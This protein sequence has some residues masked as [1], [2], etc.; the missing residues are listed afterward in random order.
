MQ[1]WISVTKT[2]AVLAEASP[3]RLVRLEASAVTGLEL[4]YGS[5]VRARAEDP[6]P[7][8][9]DFAKTKFIDAEALI[10]LVLA[11]NTWMRWTGQ[12]TTFQNIAPN[13]HQ[14]LE[15]MNVFSECA[16]CVDQDRILDPFER[17]GRSSSS[18]KLFELAPIS[19]QGASNETDVVRAVQRARQILGAFGQGGD[20]VGRLLTML[21]EV[22]GNVIHSLDRGFAAMQRYKDGARGGRVVISVGDLGIGIRESL[23]R[24]PSFNGTNS[25]LKNGSDFILE[26]MKMGV[27]SRDTVAGTGLSHVR[28]LV[29][30]WKGS[31][32]IRSCR[33]A[34]WIEGNRVSV[35]DD[36]VEF[37][38]TQVTINIRGTLEDCEGV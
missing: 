13:V 36:L 31:L 2:E 19:S 21:S 22:S 17:L 34:V 9:L 25:R 10:G 37:P 1:D 35:Q 14:Y 24:K 5:L 33:A 32:R 15:R 7:L 38:G 27:S 3:M 6:E 26:A 18:A 16:H 20:A 11:A 4:M 23:T 8:R 12:R 28:N 29:E 30:G